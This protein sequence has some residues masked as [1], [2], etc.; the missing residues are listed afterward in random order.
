PGDAA[1]RDALQAQGHCYTL[2]VKHSDGTLEP[3]TIGSI[4]GYHFAP[5]DPA[6]VLAR[7]TDPAIRL[8]SLTVTEGG[9]HLHPVTGELNLADA[10]VAHDLDQDLADPQTPPRSVF[11]YLVEGLRRR[12]AAGTA[13]FT[14]L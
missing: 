4:I 2:V 7:L 13:P 5:D 12:R 9:Y 11:G 3:Q 1:M 14:V 6:A 8:V 10:A